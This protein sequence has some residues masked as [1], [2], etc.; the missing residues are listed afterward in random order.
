MINVA[1]LIVKCHKIYLVAITIKITNIIAI[2]VKV[3][4]TITVL[5]LQLK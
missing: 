1:T 2:I 3:T 5:Q 4:V